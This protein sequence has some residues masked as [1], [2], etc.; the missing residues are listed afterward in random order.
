MFLNFGCPFF[1]WLLY[2]GHLKICFVLDAK[3]YWP[4][5]EQPWHPGAT[6]GFQQR[7]VWVGAFRPNPKG[8]IAK[9]T[10]GPNY[11]E[12][13]TKGPN[14][15]GR[16]AISSFQM[17]IGRSTIRIPDQKSLVFRCPFEKHTIQQS[18]TFWPFEYR[19]SPVFGPN[20]SSLFRSPCN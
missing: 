14:P 10:R 19:T 1:R 7:S 18:D 5:L 2:L 3:R 13:F 4:K 8:R 12:F 11:C 17:P 16:M 9:K 20:C 15:E 6:R